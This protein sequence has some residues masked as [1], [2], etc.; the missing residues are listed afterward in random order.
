MQIEFKQC[1]DCSSL[2]ALY[3]K[4]DCSIYELMRSKWMAHVY[5][6]ESDFDSAHYKTLLRLRKVVLG[7]IY[8]STYPCSSFETQD[9]ITFALKHLYK[10]NRCPECPCEDFSDFITTS[11]STSTSTSTTTTSTSTTTSTTLLP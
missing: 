7:R 6:V 1:S 8:N 2:Q 5:G 3:T 11:T 4:I 9:I 10:S